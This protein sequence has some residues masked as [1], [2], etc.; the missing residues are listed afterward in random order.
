MAVDCRNLK[1]AAYASAKAAALREAAAPPKP[2]APPPPRAV[3]DMSP[4][5]HAATVA[6]RPKRV[7]EMNL[8]EYNAAKAT[9][10]RGN[11]R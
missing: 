1:G 7:A 3:T 4:E 11:R 2:P 10:I 5:E 8:A 9:F 6:A